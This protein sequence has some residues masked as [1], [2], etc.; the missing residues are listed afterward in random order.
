VISAMVVVAV[1]VTS[2][3]AV[4]SVAPEIQGNKC[5]K[6]GSIRTYK[7]RVGGSSPSTPTKYRTKS[8]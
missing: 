5:S 1:V 2:G 4:A 3:S 7:E 8:L 6:V